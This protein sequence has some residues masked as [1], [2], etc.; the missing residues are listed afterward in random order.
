MLAYVWGVQKIWEQGS[1]A[2]S[3]SP[4]THPSQRGLTCPIF[5]F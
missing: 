5:P 2:A 1:A 3:W 4:E